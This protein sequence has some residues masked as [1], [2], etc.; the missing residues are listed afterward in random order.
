M[1]VPSTMRRAS[2]PASQVAGR[3]P[4]CRLNGRTPSPQRAHAR[5]LHCLRA[6]VA[7]TVKSR[8]RHG[9]KAG[10]RKI[11][12]VLR[13]LVVKKRWV[14][15]VVKRRM[16]SRQRHRA[17]ALHTA[18]ARVRVTGA[19]MQVVAMLAAVRDSATRVRVQVRGGL[20]PR[21][22][23]HAVVAATAA[24]RRLAGQAMVVAVAVAG[25]VTT[26]TA[27]VVVPATQA[28]AATTVAAR[29]VVVRAAAMVV[30]TKAAA[31]AQARHA[32]AGVIAA[33]HRTDAAVAARA[34]D[35]AA[36]P[37]VAQAATE[38]A[39]A[40]VAVASQVTV[41]PHLRAAALALAAALVTVTA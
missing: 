33:S 18:V 32:H 26:A 37:V 6:S 11:V 1:M 34:G 5:A 39:A 28:A 41:G 19:V 24:T 40:V 10:H 36:V 25:A 15:G 27:A 22:A 2:R 3:V 16:V 29:V 35:M 4:N 31:Q 30:A 20:G 23:R 8:P 21:A 12:E 7:V 9:A 13:A 14:R 38:I 17:D